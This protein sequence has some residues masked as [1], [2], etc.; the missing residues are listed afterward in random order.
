MDLKKKKM[1]LKE[2]KKDALE[3]NDKLRRT[4]W[5]GLQAITVKAGQ[6][7]LSLI[8]LW[9]NIKSREMNNPISQSRR[10]E[11]MP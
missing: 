1:H 10:Y 7:F 4:V 6:A 11:F 2:M 5:L 3:R 9:F 8:V